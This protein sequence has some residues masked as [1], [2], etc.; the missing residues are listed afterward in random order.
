[1]ESFEK[2]YEDVSNERKSGVWSHFL[3]CREDKSA[4]CKTCECVLNPDGAS[5][6]MLIAHLQYRHKIILKRKVAEEP[7][8]GMTSEKKARR[9]MS[10]GEEIAKMVAVNG[11]N[12]N[13]IANTDCVSDQVSDQER[14]LLAARS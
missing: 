6:R 3:F 14:D 10:V 12:F 1:M 9:E 2:V 8:V 5:T 7:S 4:K 13:Q 11:L